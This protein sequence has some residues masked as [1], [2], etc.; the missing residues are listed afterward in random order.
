MTHAEN[1]LPDEVEW[2]ADQ[3]KKMVEHVESFIRGKSDVV[4]NALIC[5]IS[6]AVSY[7]HLTLPTKA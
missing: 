2:F 3:F 6:E 4:R 7:T 1:V 5:M